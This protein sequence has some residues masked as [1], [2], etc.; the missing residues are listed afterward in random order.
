MHNQNKV[1]NTLT[2]LR[3]LPYRLSVLSNRISRSLTSKYEAQFSLTLAQWRT[4]AILAEESGLT[5]MEVAKRTAMDKVAISRSVNKL[6]DNGRIN[7]VVSTEDKRKS[8]LSL[9][10]Q[11]YEIYKKVAPMALAYESKLLE[12]LTKEEQKFLDAILTKLDNIQ[13]NAEDFE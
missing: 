9:S 4:I 1:K 3:F 6:I 8:V 12:K 5:A 11:G 10:P 7:K 13:L 2:L